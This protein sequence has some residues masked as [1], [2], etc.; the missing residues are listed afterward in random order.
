M[1]RNTTTGDKAMQTITITA[2]DEFG[3]TTIDGG[4]IQNAINITNFMEEGTYK[5][6]I[7]EEDGRHS[8]FGGRNVWANV[9][10]SDHVAC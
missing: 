10:A 7:E 2:T 8:T 9:A 1:E 4:T 3:I 5:V 6:R